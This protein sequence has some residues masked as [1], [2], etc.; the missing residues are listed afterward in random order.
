MWGRDYESSDDEFDDYNSDNSVSTMP[1]LIE[2]EDDSSDDESSDDDDYKRGDAYLLHKRP[3]AT[4]T[5][6]TNTKA[7]ASVIFTLEDKDGTMKQY[8]GLLHIGSTGGLISKEL[9]DAYDFQLKKDDNT[10]GTN[11]GNVKTSGKATVT[12]LGFHNSLIKE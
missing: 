1:S 8:L 5:R 2:R 6:P 4:T 10:W 7:R 9:V 11:A 3:S 12:G